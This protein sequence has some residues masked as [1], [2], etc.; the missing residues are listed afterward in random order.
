MDRLRLLKLLY[1]ADREALAKRGIP[2][3]GGR[4][5]A[6]DNGPL[7]CTI[8]DLIKG[9]HEDAETWAT[10]FKN[11]GYVVVALDEPHRGELSPF[12]IRILT[13]MS[14]QHRT[15]DTWEVVEETHRFPEW[16]EA[17]TPGSSR[18]IPAEK[19]L[20]AVGA[21]PEAIAAVIEEAE[22]HAKFR[23]ALIA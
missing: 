12:E 21:P 4:V 20:E 11:E 15:L 22:A 19:I 17:H 7:H 6:L 23:R 5:A 9:E 1:M 10:Y 3:V 2:I 14:E 13:S 16:K 18:T 8:Y